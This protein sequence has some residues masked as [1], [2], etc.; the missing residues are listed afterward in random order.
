MYLQFVHPQLTCQ[1]RFFQVVICLLSEGFTGFLKSWTTCLWG[2]CFYSPDGQCCR[3][4]NVTSPFLMLFSNYVSQLAEAMLSPCLCHLEESPLVLSH[5]PSSFF[6]LLSIFS[7]C[8]SKWGL[9]VGG[10]Q[11]GWSSS[12]W[13]I[14]VRVSKLSGLDCAPWR[15]AILLSQAAGLSADAS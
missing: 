7:G 10:E 15:K 4:R 9:V 1:S 13:G 3:Y 11:T 2:G 12:G 14:A 6:L 8:L 5:Y